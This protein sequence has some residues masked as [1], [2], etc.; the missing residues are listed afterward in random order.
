[1]VKQSNTINKLQKAIEKLSL[2][3]GKQE[4]MAA[5][6]INTSN[7]GEGIKKIL[8]PVSPT[9]FTIMATVLCGPPGET[10][11]GE[12]LKSTENLLEIPIISSFL[13]TF[14]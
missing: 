2:E 10:T 13:S 4:N 3:K 7:S 5:T 12:S 8:T 1:M 6:D 11:F 9:P 14:C